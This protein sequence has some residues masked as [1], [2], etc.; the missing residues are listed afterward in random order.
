M[1]YLNELRQNY[2]TVQPVGA[3][4]GLR[5]GEAYGSY[6]PYYEVNTPSYTVPN[7]Y[8]AAQAGLR[9]NEFAYSLTI[10]RMMAIS[11]ARLCMYDR[12]KEGMV[13]KVTNHEMLEFL[14]SLNDNLL[15][16]SFWA[17]SEE[18]RCI[19]GFGAWEIETTR[20]GKPKKLW[21]LNPTYSSFM[22]GDQQYFRCIRYQP[23]GMQPVDIPSERILLF[24]GPDNFDPLYPWL[25]WLSP[26]AL[27][28]P[29]LR[30]DTAMTMFLQDFI[31]HGARV[32]GLISVQQTLDD[33]TS[34]EIRDR[35]IKQHGG[36]GNWT[37]PA[38]MG[39]GA[40]WEPM[41]M[42]FS[43]MTFPVLDARTETRMCNAFQVPTIVA[44]ARA[45]LEVASYNNQIEA[46]KSWHRKWVIP[47]WNI[48]AQQFQK[49]LF[50]MF[51]IDEKRYYMAFDTSEVY[52]LQEDVVKKNTMWLQAAKDNVLTRDQTLH[53]MGFDPVD[54]EAVYVG[55]T[56][57]QNI[58][59]PAPQT[60]G[61]HATPAFEETQTH[62]D[63]PALAQPRLPGAAQTAVPKAGAT[64]QTPMPRAGATTQT[65]APIS[66]TGTSTEP[67]HVDKVLHGAEEART[68][69]ED[70]DKDKKDNEKKAFAKYAKARVREG[71]R[72]E[73]GAFEFKYHT[74]DEITVMSE[75]YLNP[76]A[77][78][79]ID[80]IN[81]ALEVLEKA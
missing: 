4:V 68:A 32:N 38:V 35:W 10:R 63:D 41:Q 57:R 31:Q 48:Y 28:F 16:P 36:T 78:D 77:A 55:M 70:A 33:N 19:G 15:E 2:V 76:Q 43:D 54:N 49:K 58:A 8:S 30:V 53:E 13:K 25:R 11:N 46:H 66:E 29:Q 79:V 73:I 3:D 27:C 1:A 6:F 39:Q 9:S 40:K 59:T 26:T 72:A 20:L 60:M 7:A 42:N 51:D 64:T 18:S 47:T 44:D 61:P 12:K 75:P 21:Y 62:A 80:A 56:I 74:L 69:K 67:E 52:D 5:K 24:F 14:G 65:P 50:P 23:Y 71:K 34:K 37:S 81:R 45:G 22:R 17:T